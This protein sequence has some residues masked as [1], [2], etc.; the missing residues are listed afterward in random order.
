VTRLKNYCAFNFLTCSRSIS[1]AIHGA[2][3]LI[4]IYGLFNSA[5]YAG[6]IL[7]AN[8]VH[9]ENEYHLNIVMRINTTAEPIWQKLTDY[10]NLNKI[11]PT[12][13][14]SHILE[15]KNKTTRVKV[16][17]EG[18]ILFFCRTIN[19]IQD[20]QIRESATQNKR[21]LIIN[22]VEGKSDFKTGY[23]LWQI[24]PELNATRVTIRA[25]L[26]PDFWIPPILGTWLFKNKLLEQTTQLITNLETLAQYELQSK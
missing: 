20:I 21:E 15:I 19:Q 11:S 18:C 24:E 2:F 4:L 8:V 26:N 25:R 22:D 9:N 3:Y 6:D 23:T 10:E 13:V 17:S 12:V 16:T 1:Q 5:T 14:R 7:I